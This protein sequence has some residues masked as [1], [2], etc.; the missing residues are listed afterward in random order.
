MN[1]V[2]PEY[3]VSA[4]ELAEKVGNQNLRLFDVTVSLKA[5]ESGGYTV[6]VGPR[7]IREIAYSGCRVYRPRHTAFRCNQPGSLHPPT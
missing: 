4:H 7:G 6:S 3:L 5:G 1:F 2:H